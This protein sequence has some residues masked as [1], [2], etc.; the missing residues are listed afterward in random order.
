[1]ILT[2]RQFQ[3]IWCQIL[4]VFYSDAVVLHE[5]QALL[6][7]TSSERKWPPRCHPPLSFIVYQ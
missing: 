3:N 5:W 7:S 4:N 1:M 6:I 2:R